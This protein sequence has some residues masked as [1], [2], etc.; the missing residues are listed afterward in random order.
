MAIASDGTSVEKPAGSSRRAAASSASRSTATGCA[1]AS[2][3]GCT[4]TTLVGPAPRCGARAAAV[5]AWR[6]DSASDRSIVCAHLFAVASVEEAPSPTIS[7]RCTRV[8]PVS[9]AVS[10]YSPGGSVTA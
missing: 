9:S 10:V 2:A 7:G 3:C 1:A 6:G 8:N 5:G 4:C